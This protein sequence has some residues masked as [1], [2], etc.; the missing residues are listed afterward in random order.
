MLTG[1]T[2]HDFLNTPEEVS[3]IT[4]VELNYKSSSP[5]MF[6]GEGLQDLREKQRYETEY[7]TRYIYKG[8]RKESGKKIAMFMYISV[9]AQ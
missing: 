5:V 7:N 3:R 6:S 1:Y 2:L 4:H 9:T 8:V